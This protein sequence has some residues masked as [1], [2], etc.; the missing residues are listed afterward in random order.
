MTG[1]CAGHPRASGS[2]R[3]LP[4][5]AVAV[6][7]PAGSRGLRYYEIADLGARGFSPTGPGAPRAARRGAVRG[8]RADLVEDKRRRGQQ[9]GGDRQRTVERFE[10]RGEAARIVGVQLEHG[11]APLDVVARLRQAAD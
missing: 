10:R 11:L 8:L 9:F 4:G 5:L 7:V 6:P 3:S 2:V 1:L